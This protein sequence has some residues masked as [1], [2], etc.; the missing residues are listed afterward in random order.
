MDRTRL[1]RTASLGPWS[2]SEDS[3]ARGPAGLV[4][5]AGRRGPRDP[6][7][8]GHRRRAGRHDLPRARTRWT[9]P[10]RRPSR[11]TRSWRSRTAR[12][13]VFADKLWS[14]MGL[15]WI[16][17]TLYV[18][19]APFLSAFRDTDGDGKADQRVDLMTGLG[20][21][22]PG[23]N[24]INDHVASGIRLGMDGFLYISVGDKGIP[25]GVGKDGTTIRRRRRRRDP[26]PARRD[27][28]GSRLDG[29][30]EPALG[31]PDATG[32]HLHLRQRR[33][34]QEVAQQPDPPHRRRALRLSLPVPERARSR[35]LPIVGGQL[36]G[37]GTQGICYNE[38]GLPARVS[39]QP[40]LLRL[41][42]AR[43]LPLRG[44]EGG[45]D[46]PAR[47]RSPA[48]SAGGP[49]RLPAVLD[50]RRARRDSRSTSSTGPSTA[51]SPTARRRAGS[52]R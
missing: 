28:A 13:R 2:V 21:K 34:Q 30:A 19:H 16:D 40:L 49:G 46:V 52:T 47:R 35:A 29:R 31:R 32:R 10:G 25:E 12:S 41:G 7:S 11:S 6:L 39:R 37:S 38:D 42:P 51:G 36:G 17:G 50:R 44:R 23:F 48:S 8:H 9:C 14:V 45:R 15:E 1:A 5:R 43:G 4:D 33:R 18:V 22:L 26:H 24:G 27:R 20:P 3:A